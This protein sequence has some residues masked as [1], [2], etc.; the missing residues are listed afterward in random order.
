MISLRD[1]LCSRHG[2][3]WFVALSALFLAGCEEEA[4]PEIPVRPVISMMIGDVERFRNDTYPGR[5]KA[6]QEVN[7]SFEV[8]GKMVERRVDVRFWQGW[9]PRRPVKRSR[10][11]NWWRG[12][13]CAPSPEI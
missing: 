11:M 5:A 6:T 2:F 12:L 4:V 1:H 8:S 9:R 3:G 7:V 13:A 10:P